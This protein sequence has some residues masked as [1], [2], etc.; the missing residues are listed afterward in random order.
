[1]H[2]QHN[3][4]QKRAKNEVIGHFI[5]LGWF[6]WF[7]ISILV[8]SNP[9]VQGRFR[10]QK[11]QSYLQRTEGKQPLLVSNRVVAGLQE[12]VLVFSEYQLPAEGE[13]VYQWGMSASVLVC[14]CASL[15]AQENLKA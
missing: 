12:F 6:D 3:F 9:Y 8:A 10:K 2:N 4:V 14:Q 11:F 15:C 7:E 13:G 5:E 1:M